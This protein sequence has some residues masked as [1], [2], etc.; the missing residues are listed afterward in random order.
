[1][2]VLT[3][4]FFGAAFTLIAGTL[5]HFVYGWSDR[6]LAMAPFAAV[7]ESVWEHLKLLAVPML[8]FAV[9]EYFCY[10]RAL[11]G[12]V[13]KQTGQKQVCAEQI[14]FRN[15]D[16]EHENIGKQE[17]P[18]DDAGIGIEQDH[19]LRHTEE[20]RRGARGQKTGQ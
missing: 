3:W 2:N 18:T 16:A 9:V 11:H 8:L 7:N 4:Q 5:L 19:D 6:S 15:A 17:I 12:T 14:G 20:N 10:G 1:M 13:C